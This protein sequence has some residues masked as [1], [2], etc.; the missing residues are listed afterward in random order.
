MDK[1]TKATHA[2]ELASQLF[3]LKLLELEK[4]TDEQKADW[5]SRFDGLSKKEF[6]YVHKQV[7]EAK[8]DHQARVGWQAIPHDVSVVVF[9]F[10]T[11]YFSLKIGLIVG[12][13][14]L[15]FLVNL[16]QIYYNQKAYKILS[17]ANILT[18]PSYLLLAYALTQRGMVWW[19][20]ALIVLATWGGTFLLG[21]IMSI[22]T[23]LYLQAREKSKAMQAEAAAGENGKK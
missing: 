4:M 21:Y 9:C 19:Q 5:M 12:I 17:N 18:Y 3:D 16:V 6:D 13:A 14:L 15:A 22:P 7:L 20:T 1:E 8:M 11:Y 2:K 10:V 23:G